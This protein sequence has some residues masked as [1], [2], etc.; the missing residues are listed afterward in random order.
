MQK[1]LYYVHVA[2]MVLF[3]MLV[4]TNDSNFDSHVTDCDSTTNQSLYQ[5]GEL[6]GN[7]NVCA[8]MSRIP[9]YT[10]D[11]W[12][13]CRCGTKLR[14]MWQA[15]ALS[16]WSLS[17]LRYMIGFRSG[18]L[19]CLQLRLIY[20]ALSL[21]FVSTENI[22]APSL[23]VIES[24]SSPRHCYHFLSGTAA[25]KPCSLVSKSDTGSS[26]LLFRQLQ[27]VL[28]ALRCLKVW[29]CTS[30]LGLIEARAMRSV[31]AKIC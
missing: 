19:C 26:A 25:P 22:L 16:P 24:A 30:C 20:N 21:N 12:H 3:P 7:S 1:V 6:L 8:L 27:G 2:V 31:R 9:K 18:S 5:K 10:L 14:R 23:I 4:K 17:A 11:G 15:V 28:Y 29:M 13:T